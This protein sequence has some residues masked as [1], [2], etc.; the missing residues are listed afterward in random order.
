MK[1]LLSIIALS[2]LVGCTDPGEVYINVRG[3][4]KSHSVAV[5][6]G[7]LKWSKNDL[8]PIWIGTGGKY[9]DKVTPSDIEGAKAVERYVKSLGN[10]N[11]SD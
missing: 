1:P 11:P 9:D 8:L 4:S 2:L 7:D 3:D 5:K 10:T 6:V